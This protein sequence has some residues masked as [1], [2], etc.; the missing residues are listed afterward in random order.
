MCL[1]YDF[2]LPLGEPHYFSETQQPDS[3]KNTTPESTFLD[4]EH[5]PFMCEHFF[6]I[7]GLD[8]FGLSIPGS[9]SGL[10]D[11]FV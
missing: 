6:E 1:Q 2:L 10:G 5:S 9:F 7:L 3:S 4:G 11:F 8:F